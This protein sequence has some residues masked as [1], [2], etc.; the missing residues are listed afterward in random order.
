MM[1]KLRRRNGGDDDIDFKAMYIHIYNKQA[2]P[3]VKNFFNMEF[4]W[5]K[6]LVNIVYTHTDIYIYIH[7]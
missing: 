1:K 7:E 2:V 3:A 6:K 5:I 4:F